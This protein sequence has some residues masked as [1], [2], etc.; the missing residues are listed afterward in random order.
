MNPSPVKAASYISISIYTTTM[1]MPERAHIGGDFTSYQI[2]KRRQLAAE[3]ENNEGSGYGCNGHGRRRV[4]QGASSARSGCAS[5]HTQTA[6]SRYVSWRGRDR[7][8]RPH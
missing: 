5:F 8:R 3:G 7:Y 4:S 2:Q 1:R 6:Q